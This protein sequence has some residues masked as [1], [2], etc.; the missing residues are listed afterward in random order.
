MNNLLKGKALVLYESGNIVWEN[1]RFAA[2]SEEDLLQSLRLETKQESL[3]VI[4]KAYMETNGRIS[5]IT[6]HT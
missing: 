4:E 5:F 1:M 6:R 3:A 2:L